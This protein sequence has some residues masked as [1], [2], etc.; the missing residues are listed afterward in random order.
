MAAQQAQVEN[1]N[2]EAEVVAEVK[3]VEEKPKKKA[4]AKKA[5]DKDTE[6]KPAKKTAAKKATKKDEGSEEK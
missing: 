4:P 1:T 6:A 3:E 5:A 2:V